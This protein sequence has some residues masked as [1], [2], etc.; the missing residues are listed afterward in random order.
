[1]SEK[2]KD[3]DIAKDNQPSTQQDSVENFEERHYQNNTR[4]EAPD[5]WPEPPKSEN[6]EEE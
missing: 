2:E 3:I 4:L 1:M 5:K 6:I